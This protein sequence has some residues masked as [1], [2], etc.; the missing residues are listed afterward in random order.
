MSMEAIGV[1]VRTLRDKHGLTQEGLAGLVG[2]SEKTMRNL[3]SGRHDPKIETLAKI[4]AQVQ[5]SLAHV[6][7]LMDP[8]ATVEQ[9]RDLAIEA[10][11]DGG[12]TDEQRAYLESLTADQKRALLAVAREMKQ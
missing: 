11:S 12:F 10:L 6:A 5:G 7:R 8:A 2:I 3:E 4:V 1:Y 9:A